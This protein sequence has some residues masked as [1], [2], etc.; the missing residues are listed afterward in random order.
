MVHWSWAK[1]LIDLWY[2][3]LEQNLLKD[4]KHFCQIKIDFLSTN[5]MNYV[6]SQKKKTFL[7]FRQNNQN[8]PNLKSWHHLSIKEKHIAFKSLNRIRL[9]IKPVLT[10]CQL[11]TFLCISKLYTSVSIVSILVPPIS[12][13]PRCQY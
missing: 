9:T 1:F 6:L 8:I 7:G 13:Q 11:A 10:T 4:I 12:R 3:E 5:S 2:I